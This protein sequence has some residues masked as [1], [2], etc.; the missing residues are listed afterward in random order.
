MPTDSF[1]MIFFIID[2]EVIISYHYFPILVYFLEHNSAIFLFPLD[3]ERVPKFKRL[4]NW[5]ILMLVG[6]PSPF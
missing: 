3:Q 4:L 5:L 1:L 6:F 2:L